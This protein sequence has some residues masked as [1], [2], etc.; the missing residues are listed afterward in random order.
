MI[1]HVIKISAAVCFFSVA[2]LLFGGSGEVLYRQT[3]YIRALSDGT[4]KIIRST[5]GKET[6]ENKLTLIVTELT[7]GDIQIRSEKFKLGKM[8]FSSSLYCVIPK[9]KIQHD[10]N[11]AYLLD[12]LQGTYKVMASKSDM[13]FT[14]SIGIHTCRLTLTANGMGKKLNMQ[15]ASDEMTLQEMSD[16]AAGVDNR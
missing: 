13:I 11:G 7:S 5:V 10:A 9:E 4:E 14:G 12:N 8:P 15:L 16:A 6:V 2:A 1:R 3:V